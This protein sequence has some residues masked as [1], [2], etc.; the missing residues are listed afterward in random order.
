MRTS[1]FVLLLATALLASSALAQS[2]I[3]E[4]RPLDARGRVDIS[5]IKGRIEVRG[6]ERNEVQVTGTLGKG[7]ERLEIHGSR[8]QINIEVRYPKNSGWGGN[9]TGPTD[10][11]VMVPVRADVDIESVAAD[12]HVNGVASGEL[13]IS[14]VS[15]SVF[16]AAAPRK[17]EVETVSGNA[18]LTLNSEDVDVSTVSGSIVLR[19]RLS[20]DIE[21]ETVSGRIEVVVNGER[22]RELSATTVSGRAEVSTALA[23]AGEINMESV[24]GD[25]LLRLP[26][27]VSAQVGGESFSG[28]LKASGVTI[29]KRRGPGASFSTTYGSGSGRVSLETFS[30][31]AEVRLE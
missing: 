24:S 19:G 10:L 3:D 7:V 14:S 23:P 16:A 26:R 30:G 12:V 5:N 27:D 9:K 29:E 11:V 31:S 28:S 17:A 20:G 13:S 18:T 15:G 4:T 6:W 22:V 2:A 25:L 1:S 21:A 8:D